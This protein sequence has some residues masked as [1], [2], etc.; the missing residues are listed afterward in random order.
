M[1]IRNRKQKARA[2]TVQTAREHSGGRAHPMLE[3]LSLPEDVTGNTVRIILLGGRRAL[4]ENHLAVVEV[5]RERISLA[6]RAGT[7]NFLGHELCLSDVRKGALAVSGR[8]CSVE[9]PDAWREEAD[10]D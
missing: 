6:V 8:I 9:L 10:D 7:L 3:A 1:S 4:V 5:G 2:R